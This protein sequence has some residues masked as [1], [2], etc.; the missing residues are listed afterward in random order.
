M[1]IPSVLYKSSM[2]IFCTS[3]YYILQLQLINI[4]CTNPHPNLQEYPQ[5]L[6][7]LPSF[8]DFPGVFNLKGTARVSN[9][10]L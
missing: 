5:V 3:Y 4:A 7:F 1:Y 8:E 2:L 9:D 10:K 6:I